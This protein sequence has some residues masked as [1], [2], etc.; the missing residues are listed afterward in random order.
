[1]FEEVEVRGTPR[2]YVVK[3]VGRAAEELVS[4]G[5]VPL[6]DD[7][8]A[9]PTTGSNI[10]RALRSYANV[11]LFVGAFGNEELLASGADCTEARV[12]SYLTSLLKELDEMAEM[13]VEGQL[14]PSQVTLRAMWLEDVISSFGLELSYS[15][16]DIWLAHVEDVARTIAY[17]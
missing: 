14:D 3:A 12:L 1:M 5:A 9:V 7:L 6:E 8:L 16:L 11:L 17:S 10:D 15:L 2:G 4:L 13:A